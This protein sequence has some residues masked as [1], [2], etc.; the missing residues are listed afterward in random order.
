MC[1]KAT[2]CFSNKPALF[3][4]HVLSFYVI[5]DKAIKLIITIYSS[6]FLLL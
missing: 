6:A 1:Y 5:D 2:I 3:S 4:V